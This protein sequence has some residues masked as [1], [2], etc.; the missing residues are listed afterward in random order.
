MFRYER[1]QAGRMRQFHQLGLEF[2]GFNSAQSDVEAISIAWDLLLDLGLTELRLELNS[3]GTKE[4]RLNYREQLVGWLEQHKNQLDSDSQ[5]RIHTNPLRILDSKDPNTQALLK[6]APQLTPALSQASLDR[7]EQ[8]QQGL[9]AL[10]IP[11][12]LNPRLVRGLDYY[13]HTAFEITSNALG[14]QATVCGGG[15]YN[16]LVEQLGG[17][18][19]ACIGWAMGLERLVL[20]MQNQKP[21]TT[22]S[23]DLYLVSHGE[24]T[25]TQALNVARALRQLGHRVD[26]DHSGAGFAK[27]LKRASK[28]GAQWAL[29]IGEQEVIS[30]KLQLKNLKTNSS[31]LVE[32]H[33][34]SGLIS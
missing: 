11:F 15:R 13:G 30:G 2:L 7:F 16:G 32:L 29:I 12:V 26:L 31:E 20:L 17:A 1:P 33:Q 24:I 3:L 23:P 34:V 4:D 10:E 14:A 9:M 6:S 28:S 18:S 25:E 22:I 27:Q 19:T 5:S 8:V 21:I